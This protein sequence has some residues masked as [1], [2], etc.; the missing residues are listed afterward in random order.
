MMI[1]QQI[2]EFEFTEEIRDEP[3]ITSFV[4]LSLNSSPEDFSKANRLILE[5]VL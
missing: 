1:S 4:E 3:K 5:E 2:D